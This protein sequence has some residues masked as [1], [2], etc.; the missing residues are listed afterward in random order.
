M[1]QQ[2]GGKCGH[3]MSRVFC[4]TSQLFHG[5]VIFFICLIIIKYLSN[6]HKQ[7]YFCFIGLNLLMVNGNTLLFFL[8]KIY[9]VSLKKSVYVL[10]PKGRLKTQRIDFHYT[11]L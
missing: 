3:K 7:Y 1:G 11:A 8:L 6:K 9:S 4:F 2:K 10:Q 5:R